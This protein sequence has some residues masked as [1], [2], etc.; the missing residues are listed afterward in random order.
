MICKT[1]IYLITVKCL[2]PN[3]R[4]FCL[5]HWSSCFTCFF[6]SLSPPQPRRGET[7]SWRGQ[8][9]KP[10][11]SFTGEE[12]RVAQRCWAESKC[13]E[14]WPGSPARPSPSFPRH[15]CLG[16]WCPRLLQ[17]RNHSFPVAEAQLQV[18][19]L[20]ILQ[21]HP[22]PRSALLWHAGLTPPP[23]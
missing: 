18:S 3:T 23:P 16:W 14:H 5:S 21:H 12:T 8:K 2:F 17:E 6:V 10:W 15:L 11:V 4:L 20:L 22:P 9:E 1:C 19:T 7:T 13:D